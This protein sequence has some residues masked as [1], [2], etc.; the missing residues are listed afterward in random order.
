MVATALGKPLVEVLKLCRFSVIIPMIHMRKSRLR[1][2]R[3]LPP[4]ATFRN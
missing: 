1:T 3:K 2:F 4:N